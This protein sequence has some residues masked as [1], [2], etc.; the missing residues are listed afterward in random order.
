[1]KRLRRQHVDR[2]FT[3]IEVVV[4]L[5]L[6]AVLAVALQSLLV[7]AYRTAETLEARESL[8]AT[9]RLPVGLL[10]GDLEGCT[11]GSPITLE[12][13]VLT[14]TTTCALQSTVEAF[15]HAVEVSYRLQRA[16]D[17]R[18]QLKRYERELDAEEAA[19]GIVI[20]DNVRAVH[21]AV[22]DGRCWHTAW[23]PQTRPRAQAVRMS[24]AWNEAE[25][26]EQRFRM[27]PW[28]WRRHDD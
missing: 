14:F 25:T 1:M 19:P 9:R 13:D 4:A 28:T 10:R 16:D 21:F 18:L 8:H 15:R 23:P 12:R 7:H 27:A 5:S 26:T 3:L 24:L 22:H 20:A 2:A 17:D 11:P 6:G